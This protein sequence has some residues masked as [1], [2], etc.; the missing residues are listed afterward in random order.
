M[1]Q[2]RKK[3]RIQRIGNKRLFLAREQGLGGGRSWNEVLSRNLP[4]G[5]EN[6]IYKGICC[7]PPPGGGGVPI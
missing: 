3:R 1:A 2:R 6:E 7:P 4:V 5:F